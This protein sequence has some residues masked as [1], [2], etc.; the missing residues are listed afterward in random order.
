MKQ[1]PNQQITQFP[2]KGLGAIVMAAG[3]G[4][5]MR[6]KLAKVLHPVAGRPMVLY[7]VELAERLAS[8]GVAVV[9]GHPGDQVKGL[10]EARRPSAAGISPT[11]TVEV[12]ERLG[13]GN[14]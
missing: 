7:G 1:S 4:K 6:S 3:L 8:G 12:E 5:R 11:F 2:V 10:I 13:T 14:V 9:V